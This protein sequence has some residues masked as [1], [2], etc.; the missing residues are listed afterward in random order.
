MIIESEVSLDDL[1]AID[2]A[3]ASI[4]HDEEFA[5]TRTLSRLQEMQTEQYQEKSLKRK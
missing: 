1:F 2:E 5:Y 3:D 4:V